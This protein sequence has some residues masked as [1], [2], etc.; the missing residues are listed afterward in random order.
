MRAKQCN[1]LND[2]YSYI[3]Y[4]HEDQHDCYPSQWSSWWHRISEIRLNIRN[5]IVLIPQYKLVLML[6]TQPYIL[7][8]N[9]GFII[10]HCRYKR[11]C[12]LPTGVWP[13]FTFYMKRLPTLIVRQIFERILVKHFF[14][15]YGQIRNFSIIIP[16]YVRS[17]SQMWFSFIE[18]LF[19]LL[20]FCQDS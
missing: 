11:R 5:V 7:G 18:G 16:F 20:S 9:H 4:K 8:L 17:A 2:A 1:L 19:Y 6:F 13:S 14:V 10:R 15:I 12:Y 3:F